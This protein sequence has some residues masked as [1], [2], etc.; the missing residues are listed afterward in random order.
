MAGSFARHMTR[1]MHGGF[2]AS[3]IAAVLNGLYWR[4]PVSEPVRY[5]LMGSTV[6]V[7][8]AA[9]VLNARVLR[10]LNASGG[11]VARRVNWLLLVLGVL[12]VA[13]VA[14]DITG[15]RRIWGLP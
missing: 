7:A 13:S 8:A 2:W 12:V 6:L 5:L 4:V 3:V 11:R 10:Q 1:Y 14:V 9:V 15:L